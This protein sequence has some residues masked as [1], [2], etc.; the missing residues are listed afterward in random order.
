MR[1]TF[2]ID[3]RAI[4]ALGRES[5]KDSTTAILEL[6]KNSYDAGAKVVRVTLNT[7]SET[8][9]IRIVDSGL[10]M[11]ADDIESLWLRIGYSH[12]RA[13]KKV[14]GRRQL[15]EKGVGRLSADRLGRE[16]E[17]RSHKK[18]S[19]GVGI[20]VCWDHFDTSGLDIQE[21]PIEV[22]PDTAFKVPQP[23][24]YRE[25]IGEYGQAPM[26]LDST[27]SRTGTELI[28]SSLRQEWAESD[29]DDLAREL[30]ILISPF[31]DVPSFQVQ[32]NNDIRPEL[33][34]VLISPFY[35]AAEIEAE[36]S[37]ESG[38]TIKT[39]I[40]TR[41]RRGNRK[42]PLTDDIE[43][44]QFRHKAKSETRAEDTSDEED[45]SDEPRFGPVKAILYYYPRLSET[46]RGTEL[47][48]VQLRNFLDVHA[49]I[50][51]YR[52]KVRVMPYG[53]LTKAE[54][55]DWLG[56]GDRKT[57]NPAGA[58]R[59]DFRVSPNQLV[60]AVLL[61]RDDNPGL[62]D[63]TAREGLVH[64]DEFHDLTSFLMG[65]VFQLEATYHQLFLKRRASEKRKS[66]INPRETVKNVGS[67]LKALEASI[68]NVSTDLGSQSKKKFELVIDELQ[69]ASES[70][71]DLRES[72]DELAS[73]A[74]IYRGL[75]SL[76]IAM[77]T[78][79]HET[80]SALEDLAAINSA[81]LI[82]THSPEKTDLAIGELGKAIRAGDKISA[83][84]NFAL[85][86]IKPD[87]R[88]KRAIN[89][90]DLIGKL[91]AELQDA[92]DASSI[93]LMTKL[94]EI[95]GK[96]F[97]MDIES[98][99]LNLLTNAYF[100]AKLRA[101]KREV[102]LQLRKLKHDGEDGIEIAV[103][104]SGGGVPK[105]MASEIWM[106]LFSTKVDNKGRSVGSGLGL[107]IVNDVVTDLNGERWVERDKQ[108]GG[109]LFR[110]WLPLRT[111]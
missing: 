78:F 77:T 14:K 98:V 51:V 40:S 50:K 96:F 81:K 70:L 67:K 37:Y 71:A 19:E 34:G 109:A 13:L 63:T 61:T 55:G 73:Q 60:G 69:V 79:S 10:G 93:R 22:L 111:R 99:V 57:R 49:G 30:S 44:E 84:G 95:R 58:A 8:P 48:L 74:I 87:K 102:R 75:A 52:D 104:D 100:F 110:I 18:N 28:I 89:V 23:A 59:K 62:I 56:L 82:L 9:E 32:L 105:K 45:E 6:V 1:K 94:G 85:R 76:G 36:F 11:D 3:A 90:T 5:I 25:E 17:L 64:G 42:L 35:D 41:D 27:S 54:G 97:P 4:L 83:W 15:G 24:P 39:S 33:N 101:K 16:L 72:M 38:T 65:G 53:D 80:D 29:V 103:A 68:A 46:T 108:L 47:R 20:R 43:W 92:F 107:T 26:D 2:K 66:D 31:E 21:V 106:P 7:L 88:R 12:K 91:V 86:R